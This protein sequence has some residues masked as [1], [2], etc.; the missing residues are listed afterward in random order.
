MADQEIQ[1]VGQPV[2]PGPP[3]ASSSLDQTVGALQ[4]P[5]RLEQRVRR[6]QGAR[7]GSFKHT[8]CHIV[9]QRDWAMRSG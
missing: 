4:E 7:P 9:L 8:T 1:E 3:T 6:A 5:G 2:D